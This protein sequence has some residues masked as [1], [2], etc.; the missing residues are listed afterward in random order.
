MYGYNA[1]PDDHIWAYCMTLGSL[2]VADVLQKWTRN[3]H[4][5]DLWMQS[6]HDGVRSG[7]IYGHL[8]IHYAHI[9]S[10]VMQCKAMQ[11]QHSGVRSGHI[12]GHLTIH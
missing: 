9:W 5:G 6:Q 2:L 12:Y 3:H 1:W 10:Y 8:T 7:H 11:S 4:R